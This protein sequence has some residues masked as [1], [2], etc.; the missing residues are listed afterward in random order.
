M[1][2]YAFFKTPATELTLPPG[3]AGDVQIVGNAEISALVESALDLTWVEQDDTRLVQAVL[4]HDRVICELFWQTPILPLRFG[5]WFVSLESL[6]THLDANQ[7]AYLAKLTQFVGKAEYKLKIIPQESNPT[8]LSSEVKGKDYF[9]AKKQRYEFQL[10]QQTQRAAELQ[11]LLGLITQAY[12]QHVQNAASDHQKIYLLIDR[13]QEGKLYEHLQQW[14][15][16]SPLWELILGEALPPY[17][18]V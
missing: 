18:F 12:P 1:Y 5:T 10:A 14:Q 17:H 11:E 15:S 6:L 13:H 2:T 4:T 8:P 3:I 16:R 9:V 7:S